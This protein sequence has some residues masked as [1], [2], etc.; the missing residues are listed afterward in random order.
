MGA[1]VQ[2]WWREQADLDGRRLRV[3]EVWV[4]SE[5]ARL[6]QAIIVSP[7]RKLASLMP[8][9]RAMAWLRQCIKERT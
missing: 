8:W 4:G 2:R 9:A 3:E 7:A 1:G 6:A 5:E